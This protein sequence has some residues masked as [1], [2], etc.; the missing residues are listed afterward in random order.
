MIRH[1]PVQ[2]PNVHCFAKHEYEYFYFFIENIWNGRTSFSTCAN[3]CYFRKF[4]QARYEYWPIS[5]KRKQKQ[6][7]NDPHSFE[8]THFN[9]TLQNYLRITMKS[10]KFN[11]IAAR[12]LF[13][14][15]L[16]IKREK[17]T[18][19]NHKLKTVNR[20]RFIPAWKALMLST[21]FQSEV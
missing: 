13:V 16:W 3:L 4:H 11:K 21:V 20:Q 8:M 2:L 6:K 5:T 18:T 15:V 19:E 7:K 12:E 14:R 1:M 17:K 10:L 9:M